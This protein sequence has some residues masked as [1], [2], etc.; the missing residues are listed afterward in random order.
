MLFFT[1]NIPDGKRSISLFAIEIEVKFLQYSNGS[2]RMCAIAL[3]SKLMAFN[4]GV[5]DGFRALHNTLKST[6]FEC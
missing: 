3:L 6:K 5:S 1:Q 4:V 2:P